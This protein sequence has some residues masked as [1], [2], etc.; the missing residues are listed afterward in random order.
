MKQN[1]SLTIASLLSVLLF[2]LHI[3]D[4]IVRGFEKGGLSNLNAI[5]LMA[6]WLCGALLL[7]GRRSGYVV[8]LIFSLLAMGIPFLHF[9]GAAGVAGGR[10]AGTSGA[11]FFVWTLLALGVT[12]LLGF[13]LSAQGLWRTF[14]PRDA[15]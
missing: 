13:I 2:S 15:S 3:A 4:D 11:T 9:R 8:T 6:A 7:A 1:G 10:V 12:S 5:P 14:R